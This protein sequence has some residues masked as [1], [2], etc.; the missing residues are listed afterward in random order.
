MLL[1]HSVP[2]WWGHTL[3]S[4]PINVPTCHQDGRRAGAKC[5]AL[6]GPSAILKSL[7]SPTHLDTKVV[8]KSWPLPAPNTVARSGGHHHD[9]A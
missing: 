7:P 6:A 9:F 4:L 1:V 5:A 3:L 8:G 2:D